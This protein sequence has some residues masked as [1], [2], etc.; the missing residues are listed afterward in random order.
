VSAKKSIDSRI[1]W[2]Q[3]L[4]RIREFA[5]FRGADDGDCRKSFNGQGVNRWRAKAVLL[6]Q[7]LRLRLRTTCIHIW[8]SCVVL[9]EAKDLASLQSLRLKREILRCAQDDKDADRENLSS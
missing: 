8:L 3:A 2:I 4:R 5:N 6:G 9:S 1:V 7:V